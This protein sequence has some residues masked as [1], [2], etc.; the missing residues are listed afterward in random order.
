MNLV[1]IHLHFVSILCFN[2]WGRWFLVCLGFLTAVPPV[3]T[4]EKLPVQYLVILIRSTVRTRSARAWTTMLLFHPATSDKPLPL[5]ILLL[6]CVPC[7]C[8]APC[9]CCC[10]QSLQKGIHWAWAKCCGSAKTCRRR[11]AKSRRRWARWGN[12][13]MKLI[14]SSWG[15]RSKFYSHI[16]REKTAP[17]STQQKQS[18][19]FP[20][21]SKWELQM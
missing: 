5:L 2:L 1:H 12:E 9:C 15:L 20:Q 13:R 14:V 10:G 4:G 17:K 18:R 16:F 3:A 19:C 6:Q 7:A 8:A 11:W 21:Y